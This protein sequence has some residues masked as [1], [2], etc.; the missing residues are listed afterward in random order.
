MPT[1]DVQS[2]SEAL[3]AQRQQAQNQIPDEARAVMQEATAD[4]E[5]R[6]QAD[7]TLQPGD[8]A[9]SFEVLSNE[10]N[11]VAE[12]YG[13]VLQIPDALKA[14]YDKFG[15]DLPAANG[16]DSWTLPIPATFVL[17][18]TG[19]VQYAFA[20]ADYRTRAEPA[21]IL[22]TLRDLR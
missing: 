8:A 18:A 20:A 7:Q 19:A 13:L 16:D 5:A 21:A 14:V 11:A 1:T 15:I 6:G 22:D 3:A 2:L 9:P 10:G 17:D 4:L 12:R